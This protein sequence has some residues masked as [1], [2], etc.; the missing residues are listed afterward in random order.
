MTKCPVENEGVSW[1]MRYL[2][3]KW[4]ESLEGETTHR[5]ALTTQNKCPLYTIHVASSMLN[6]TSDS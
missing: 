4:G 3:L 2:A 6:L 5:G 1:D